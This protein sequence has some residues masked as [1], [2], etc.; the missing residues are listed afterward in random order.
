MTTESR[1]SLGSVTFMHLAR[2]TR[3]QST[4]DCEPV[5][6]SFHSGSTVA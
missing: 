1:R 2:K 5:D 4:R 3:S 6:N